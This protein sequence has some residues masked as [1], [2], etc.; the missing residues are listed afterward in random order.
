[1]AR[2]AEMTTPLVVS[3]AKVKAVHA[4]EGFRVHASLGL[5]G[6]GLVFLVG[7]LLDLAILWIFQR[8]ASPQWEFT[9]LASTSEGLPRLVLA[10]ALIYAALYTRGS[11]SLL[12]YRMLGLGLILV[13]LAGAVVGALMVTDYF[14]LR[15]GINPESGQLFHSMVIKTLSLCAMYVFLLVPIGVLGLRRPKSG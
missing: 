12:T 5:A 14:V 1:M 13:G 9:A 6:A 11:T 2:V 15:G 4:P 7:T 8:Q 10:F 3:T